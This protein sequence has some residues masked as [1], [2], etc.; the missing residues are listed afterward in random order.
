[1]VRLHRGGR[2]LRNYV[3]QFQGYA[4]NTKLNKMRRSLQ[5]RR[6]LAPD[7]PRASTREFSEQQSP[8]LFDTLFA[9]SPSVTLARVHHE[10][11]RR[12]YASAPDGEFEQLNLADF[13][14]R[15]GV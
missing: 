2:D 12:V 7:A 11:N 4:A 5:R 6:L 1:M 8:Y 15:F 10:G 13:S 3:L 9:V 14:R